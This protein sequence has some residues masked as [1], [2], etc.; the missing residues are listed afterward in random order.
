MSYCLLLL[1]GREVGS[2]VFA[3]PRLGEVWYELN[4][5]ATPPE[6]LRLKQMRAAVGTRARQPIY[7]ENPSNEEVTLQLSSS[8]TLNFRC[9]PPTVTL[10]PYGKTASDP[11]SNPNGLPTVEVEYAPSSLDT[12]QEATIVVNDPRGASLT[13]KFM[14]SG[15]G[16]APSMEPVMVYSAVKVR[17]PRLSHSE[18]RSLNQ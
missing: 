4:L 5:V 15:R 13:G 2:I 17:H 14:V 16:D 18:I 12:L 11:S 10:G 6:R 7:I 3:N 8:N 9:V 1:P